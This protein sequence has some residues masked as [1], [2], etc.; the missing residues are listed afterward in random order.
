MHHDLPSMQVLLDYARVVPGADARLL[1][2]DLSDMS[3]L[4]DRAVESVQTSYVANPTFLGRGGKICTMHRRVCFMAKSADSYGYFYSKQ[5]MPTTPITPEC[6]EL[7]KAVRV[8]F[9]IACNGMLFNEYDPDS[10]ISDHRDDEKN[11]DSKL[12]V[13]AINH[14][15]SRIFR[16]KEYDRTTKAACAK[17][18]GMWW[19]FATQAYTGLHMFCVDFQELLTHGVPAL[20]SFSEGLRTSITFRLHDKESEAKQYEAFVRGQRK[21]EETSASLHANK[22]TKPSA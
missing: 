16:V 19:D 12:G 4:I 17:S 5:L 7:M 14:G 13:F 22:H 10:Y 20:A 11:I 6:L 3:G 9:G 2:Y 8:T 1:Q 21:R 15:A 18:R